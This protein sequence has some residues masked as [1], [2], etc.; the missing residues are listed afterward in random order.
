MNPADSDNPWR[1]LRSGVRDRLAQRDYAE[2]VPGA[3][4]YVTGKIE[5][6]IPGVEIFE[7]VVHQ[8]RHRGYFGE[9]AREG[10]GILDLIG[11]SPRQWS[12]AR[13][14]AGTAKGFHIHPPFV[15]EGED[16]ASWFRKLYLEN[17]GD[18]SLRPHDREQW[19]VMF[20]LTGVVEMLLVDEREG[21]PRQAMRFFLDGDSA[22][23]PHKAGVVIPAGVAH[24][25]RA[26]SSEDPV[27]VYG[28]STVFAGENEG[29]IA[30]N[31]ESLPLPEE[32]E[33]FFESPSS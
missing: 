22:S 24:A 2:P 18:T 15:P 21:L 1:G 10:E 7:R 13:M 30:S 14:F 3:L 19:D 4:D 5:I 31:V 16:P 8:Q 29:R 23:G 26:A 9:L 28:T 17:P 32:W 33:R 11:F 27:M 12:A 6:G 20:F 25:L